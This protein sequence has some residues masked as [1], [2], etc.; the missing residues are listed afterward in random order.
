MRLRIA[1][2]VCLAS[3]LVLSGC[4]LGGD[5]EDGADERRA[6][7]PKSSQQPVDD[8]GYFSDPQLAGIGSVDFSVP[9][10]GAD[11]EVMTK[12]RAR[13]LSL[14]KDGDTVRLVGAWL[15]SSDGP[16]AGS[17]ILAAGRKPF[18]QSPW[19]RLVDEEGGKLY[20]P[21]QEADVEPGSY[22]R[23]D[24]CLCSRTMSRTHSEPREDAIE[25]FWV[26]FPAPESKEVRVMMG[27]HALPT[28]ALPISSGTPFDNPVPDKA[29]FKE[30]PPEQYGSED[31]Q[32]AVLP[33]QET[34]K[35]VT[36]S[37]QTH[38]GDQLQLSVTSDV[39]FDFDSSKITA[40][41]D[42]VL[43]EAAK[44]LRESAAGQTVTIVGHTDDQGEEDYNQK[45][46]EE[47]AESV[48][49]A[50]G[51]Q[52]DGADITLKT[53]GRGEKQP[54]V[55]NRTAEGDPIEE[56]RKQN[57]RVSFDYKSSEGADAKID[58]GQK[59]PDAPRMKEAETADG[60]EASALLK[61]PNRDPGTDL[62]I[63]VRG[64]EADGRYARLDYAFAPAEG[65]PKSAPA[66]FI[67]NSMVN[68]SLHFGLNA[69]GYGGAPSGSNV[70][71]I[72]EDTGEQF[73]PVTGGDADCLCTEGVA[74]VDR[75]FAEPAPMYS[76]FPAEV[77]NRKNLTLRIANSGTW[78]LPIEDILRGE[79][80]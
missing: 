73:L 34:I 66:L 47:R 64:L 74:T 23:K 54:L 30:A 15:R 2:S 4:S 13:I 18:I 10:G 48:E 61:Q 67:G 57:R 40:E 35:N 80:E 60:A 44:T 24:A 25:L 49:K 14:D 8:S 5:S 31:A 42:K 79:Q 75:L 11:G 71:L 39:L 59:L 19:I 17:E 29:E 51:K 55:P 50:I 26:D 77:L 78:P 46:S 3:L 1:A 9:D 41:G 45:L 52:L 70:S 28:T 32:R 58:A 21:L 43:G 38:E 20:E 63:D 33:L 72:D 6:D 27:E 68:K 69:Y 62:R 16:S 37:R 76:M 22:D 56:N 7:G 12:S 65:D 36:G 53:E